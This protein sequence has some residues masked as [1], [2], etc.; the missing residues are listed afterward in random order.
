MVIV[1]RGGRR[2]V[3]PANAATRATPSQIKAFETAP[4]RF[5]TCAPRD[6]GYG[7]ATMRPTFVKVRVQQVIAFHGFETVR[8][9]S[10]RS[11][12]GIRLGKGRLDSLRS[13][14]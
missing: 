9:A 3:E 5:V 2:T 11:G 1:R 14:S 12:L 6:I 13:Y 8:N 10:T 4:P 7:S